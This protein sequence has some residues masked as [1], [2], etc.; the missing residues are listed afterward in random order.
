MGKES[1]SGFGYEAS[2]RWLRQR[3][4]G[5]REAGSDKEFS[6][7]RQPKLSSGDEVMVWLGMWLSHFIWNLEAPPEHRF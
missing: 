7:V 6:V 3:A 2:Q 4:A 1:W 5:R